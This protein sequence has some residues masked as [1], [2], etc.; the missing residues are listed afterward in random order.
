MVTV[1]YEEKMEFLDRLR[2]RAKLLHKTCEACFPSHDLE[3]LECIMEDVVECHH[4]YK[5]EEK[6]V[7]DIYEEM[8]LK[9]DK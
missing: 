1:T 9:E 3:I 8:F 7:N 2:E 5:K 4:Q 6:M